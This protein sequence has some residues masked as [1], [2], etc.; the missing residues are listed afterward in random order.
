MGNRSQAHRV[1]GL[2]SQAPIPQPPNLFLQYARY[3][4]CFNS[5]RCG[6]KANAVLFAV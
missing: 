2:G 3:Y 1:C 6:E 5:R 4:N